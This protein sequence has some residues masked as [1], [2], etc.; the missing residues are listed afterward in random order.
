MAAFKRALPHMV[1][2]VLGVWLMVAP[3]VLGYTGTTAG[4]SDRFVGPLIASIAFVAASEITRPIRWLNL[5]GAAWLIVAPWLLGFSTDA[6]VND[7]L[8]GLAVA[9]LSPLGKADTRRRFGGGWKS[10]ARPEQLPEAS[11]DR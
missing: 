9:A 8:V 3:A 11:A 1:V 6:A 4:G 7:L 10:L 2:F 5:L